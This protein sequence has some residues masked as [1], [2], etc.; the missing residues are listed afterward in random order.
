MELSSIEIHVFVSV[1][2]ILGISLI[3]L[4]VDYL[5]GSNEQLRERNVELRVR[6]EEE[7][8]RS[9]AEIRLL[10]ERM[11]A[12]ANGE[13]PA[14]KHREA[15]RQP[16]RSAG[17]SPPEADLQSIQSAQMMIEQAAERAVR[18]AASE[19][20]EPSPKPEET[21][22]NSLLDHIIFASMPES[23]TRHVVMPQPEPPAPVEV[24][25]VVVAAAPDSGLGASEPSR[26][27]F[28]TP[29]EESKAAEPAHEA[30]AEVTVEPEAPAPAGFVKAVIPQA[31]GE[32][33][34][35]KTV[36]ASTPQ[37]VVEPIPPACE[38]EPQTSIPSGLAVSR[39]PVRQAGPVL[40]KP[41]ATLPKGFFEAAEIATM[42]DENE[43]ITGV[44]VAVGVSDIQRVMRDQPKGASEEL[45]N[46]IDRLIQSLIS[47]DDFAYRRTKDE[48]IVVFPNQTGLAAR[49][50]IHEVAERLWDFQLRSLAAYSVL[51]SW[52][53]VTVNNENFSE[54]VA[55]AVDEM[56]ETRDSRRELGM[57]GFKAHRRAANY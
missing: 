14:R 42:I 44:V 46:S 48:F 16:E 20:V 12:A 2:V 50:R 49:K 39:E 33:S 4:I 1:T 43:V 31:V 24:E 40:V 17:V 47:A 53:A 28:V 8:R 34:V 30:P 37:T 57:T 13:I 23:E 18:N 45:A 32:A 56:N 29:V 27:V 21:A 55:L 51:F 15:A 10:R 6:R 54:A 36:P 52:G 7:S 35:P 26:V 25:H 5:K 9:I 19:K 38:A 3:A 22:P 41:A 11:V